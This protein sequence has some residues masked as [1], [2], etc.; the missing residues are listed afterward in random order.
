MLTMGSMVTWG[1]EGEFYEPGNED[2]A[3]AGSDGGDFYNEL[4]IKDID[5]GTFHAYPDVNT[6]LPGLLTEFPLLRE[7]NPC[8]DTNE[9]LV[10]VKDRGM[11][12]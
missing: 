8:L 1:G 3:Y 2:W 11:D 10:V 4:K 9:K 6:I 12:Q 7:V 5:F